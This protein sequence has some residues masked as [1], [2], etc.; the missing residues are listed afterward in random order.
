VEV[1]LGVPEEETKQEGETEGEYLIPVKK[2]SF[3]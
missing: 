2:G 1:N 3:P